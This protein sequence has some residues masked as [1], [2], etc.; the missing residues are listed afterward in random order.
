MDRFK[1]QNMNN[2][3]WKNINMSY[4]NW[5]EQKITEENTNINWTELHKHKIHCKQN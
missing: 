4:I 3:R 5:T 2:L 1:V